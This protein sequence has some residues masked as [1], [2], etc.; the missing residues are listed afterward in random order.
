MKASKCKVPDVA[1]PPRHPNR[2]F[3]RPR[4]QREMRA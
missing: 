1:M 2:D 3:S 4:V